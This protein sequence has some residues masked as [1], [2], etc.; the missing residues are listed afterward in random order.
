MTV[1]YAR[2]SSARDEGVSLATGQTLSPDGLVRSPHFF[3]G[4][5]LDAEQCARGILAVANVAA[6]SYYSRIEWSSLD[7][8]VT[9]DG[10]RL[11]LSLI[12]I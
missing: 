12:H 8:V 6:A 11:R 10:E 7:P 9:S 5:V 1:T 4:F 3:S 2:S